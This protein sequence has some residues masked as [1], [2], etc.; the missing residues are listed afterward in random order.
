M[1]NLSIW[2]VIPAYN[3][4]PVLGNVLRELVEHN[5]SFNIVVVDD[6]STDS[7]A[8]EAARQRRVHLL[9]HPIN[10]GQGAALATG[11][12][13]ALVNKADVVVTFDA[14]GQMN[15]SDIDKLIEKIGEGYDVVLG[16]RFLN[17]QPEGM[18]ALRKFLLKLAVIFTRATGRLEVTDIHNGLRAFRSDALKK[19]VITQSQMAH[20]SEIL[21]EIARNRLKYCEV[22]VSIRYTDYSKAKGQSILNSINVI[23][24]LLTGA[25]K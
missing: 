9:R 6:G 19:I 24:E 20:A 16:S 22:P 11:F 21:S 18:P 7:T 25:K 15:P 4:Q 2:V 13:Y 5:P 23:Y 8:E 12:E 3:E 17:V 14:D 10:L 1:T